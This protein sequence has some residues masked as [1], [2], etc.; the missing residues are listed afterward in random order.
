VGPKVLGSGDPAGDAA[1]EP[2]EDGR[3]LAPTVGSG[4]APAPVAG[5]SSLPGGSPA[6]KLSLEDLPLLLGP[7]ALVIAGAMA[8]G[9]VLGVFFGS[10]F[11]AYALIAGLLAA[12]PLAR[13]LPKTHSEAVAV[14][15]I[16]EDRVVSAVERAIAPFLRRKPK[17]QIED[18]PDRQ[19]HR[20]QRAASVLVP[21]A[22]LSL[23][24]GSAGK[25][26]GGHPP[27]PWR[28]GLRS[29]LTDSDPSAL[30]LRFGLDSRGLTDTELRR[31]VHAALLYLAGGEP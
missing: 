27:P 30:D 10:D 19:P 16:R 25:F 22:L 9:S 24:S 4:L 7:I 29:D 17:S 2:P 20:N 14:A 12:L 18:V 31:R 1:G 23:S 13:G 3:E 5:E 11:R 26:S 15:D 21:V 28:A 6:R 8:V